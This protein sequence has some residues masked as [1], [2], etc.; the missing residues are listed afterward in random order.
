MTEKEIRALAPEQLPVNRE[1][2]Y[3]GAHHAIT[4]DQLVA[5]ESELVRRLYEK[6]EILFRTTDPRAADEKQQRAQVEAFFADNEMLGLQQQMLKVRDEIASR[7]AQL[8]LA[9]NRLA[10]GPLPSIA[11]YGLI[12]AAGIFE[13]EYVRTLYYLSRDALKIIRAAV[14]DL[15]PVERA[16]DEAARMHSAE[17]LVEKWKNASY[18]VFEKQLSVKFDCHYK[19]NIAERCLEFAELDRIF[20]EVANNAVQFAS[21]PRLEIGVAAVDQGRSLRFVFRNPIDEQRAEALEGVV[22]EGASLFE[23]GVGEDVDRG[24]GLG[25]IADS[26]LHAY[27]LE[28]LF[29]AEKRGY[30]GI[31]FDASTFTLWLH[32]PAVGILPG[33]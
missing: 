1:M 23:H 33:E 2:R 26:V 8:A 25:S 6:I 14:L 22:H 19:G 3:G 12:I 24:F 16:R 9:W 27:G 15:D 7:D 5:D 31:H 32:W 28:D 17:L 10:G 21:E 29:A 4:L 13:R 30:L 18:R 11:D 20:Y